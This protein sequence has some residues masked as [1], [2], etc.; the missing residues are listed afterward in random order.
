MLFWLLES[1]HVLLWPLN[2]CSLLEGE[3]VLLRLGLRGLLLGQVCEA[4]VTRGSEA[5][6]DR[7]WLLVHRNPLDLDDLI[8]VLLDLIPF[9]AFAP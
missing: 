5:A 9:L 2:L 6:L 4:L 7:L 1:Q 8:Q 3:H